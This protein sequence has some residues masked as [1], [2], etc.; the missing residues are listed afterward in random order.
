MVAWVTPGPAGQPVE[1]DRR[2]SAT[3]RPLV[4]TAMLNTLSS[5]RRGRRAARRTP[6][7]SGAGRWVESLITEA[8]RRGVRAASLS[9]VTVLCRAARITGTNVAAIATPSAKASTTATVEPLSAGALAAPSRPAPGPSINGA[10]SRPASSPTPAAHRPI[11]MCSTSSTTA[12]NRG[13]PPTAL[14]RPTRRVC[15]AIRPPT[16]TTTLA[17]ASMASSQLPAV[18]MVCTLVSV[19]ASPS[20]IC[21]QEIR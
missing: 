10:A 19:W 2:D 14:S 6:S 17:I 18:K 13:V 7:S 5:S 16:S 11:R 21:C 8:R 4:V 12:T 9:A 15:S 20:R 1:A 3:T